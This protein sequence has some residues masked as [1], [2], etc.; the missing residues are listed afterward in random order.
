ML[1]ILLMVRILI[2]AVDSHLPESRLGIDILSRLPQ[3]TV[4]HIREQRNRKDI[5]RS[6]AAYSLL[7]QFLDS[8]GIDP[9]DVLLK[10]GP[11]GKPELQ[12]PE[13]VFFNCSHSGEWAICGVSRYPVGV[14]MEEISFPIDDSVYVYLHPKEREYL[15]SYPKEL[16]N[17]KFIG[18]WTYKEAYLK[19]LGC[20]LLRDPA[21]FAIVSSCQGKM[22]VEDPSCPHGTT[23]LIMQKHDLPGFSVAACL[24]FP[25]A[26]LRE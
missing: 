25:D 23:P 13:G 14:D 2:S 16:R 3:E 24:L 5:S 12:K 8:L 19:A 26:G 18:L 21:S 1:T 4:G 10:N 6:L 11:H 15:E 17:E 9:G 20:G 7:F 22:R